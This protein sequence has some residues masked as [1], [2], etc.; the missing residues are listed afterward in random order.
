MSSDES[1][2]ADQPTTWTLTAIRQRGFAL[3]GY[4][5][6]A[7]CGHFYAFDIDALIEACGADYLV[8]EILPG[9]TCGQCNGALKFMLASPAQEA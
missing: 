3:E 1:G 4:C 9:V 5:Q 8:P 2:P 6:T 7:G